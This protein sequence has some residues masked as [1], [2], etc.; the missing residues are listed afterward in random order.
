MEQG[1]AQRLSWINTPWVVGLAL[2]AEPPR[3]QHPHSSTDSSVGSG[4]MQYDVKRTLGERGCLFS[5]RQL[6]SA[7]SISV[8]HAMFD[9]LWAV[10]SR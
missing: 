3:V 10:L 9:P 5:A 4:L 8:L 2:G 7:L 6:S 1:R